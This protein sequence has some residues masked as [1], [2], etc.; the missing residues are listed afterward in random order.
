MLRWN[1]I[2]MLKWIILVSCSNVFADLESGLE[3]SQYWR[4]D[5][6]DVD[7]GYNNA[8]KFSIGR[9]SESKSLSF[10]KSISYVTAPCLNLTTGES[11]TYSLW[12]YIKNTTKDKSPT[13][14]AD[15]RGSREGFYLSV[16]ERAIRLTVVLGGDHRELL[17]SDVEIKFNTWT[18]FAITF[19]KETDG[20]S[21]YIDGK[22]QEH[23]S[24]W[25]GIDYF[26]KEPTCTIGNMPEFRADTKYQLYGSV[27]DLYVLSTASDD[28]VHLL[29]GFPVLNK[30]A[31]QVNGSAVLVKWTPPITGQCPV[32][33][34]S[35]YY[36]E[37]LSTEWTS[38]MVMKNTT[39]YVLQLICAK[40]YEIGVTAWNTN[41]ETSLND[42][43]LW[44]VTTGGAK[45]SPPVITNLEKSNC[46]VNLTWSVNED[47][48]CPLIKYTIHY[49]QIQAGGS[50][51]DSWSKIDITTVSKMTHQW[52]LQCDT[53]YEFAV[54]A[55]NVM[56]QSNLSATWQ[57]KTESLQESTTGK[58]IGIILGSISAFLVMIVA[59][60]CYRRRLK[61]NRR[62]STI[63]RKWSKS[64]ITPLHHLE[65][66]PEQ[67]TLLEE[68]GRGAFGKVHKAVLRESPGVEVFHSN[69]R[70]KRV[71]FKEGRTIAVKVLSALANEQ[72]KEQ[73]VEEIDLMKQIG[74]HTNVLSMIGFWTR[75]EPFLLLL[76]YAPCGD[77]LHWLRE[78]R[79]Q[80]D[81]GKFPQVQKMELLT[82][83]TAKTKNRQN[84][85]GI[86]LNIL[87]ESQQDK[88]PR[89][90]N[91][92][93]EEMKN[94]TNEIKDREVNN[95]IGQFQNRSHEDILEIKKIAFD[96]FGQEVDEEDNKSLESKR[97]IKVELDKRCTEPVEVTQEA[98]DDV[99]DDTGD[100][101][102]KDMLSF[103][104]Q[105]ARGM[106][107]LSRRGFIHRDL[108]AR[109]VL[110]GED[111]H[112]KIAD[113]G[114]MRHTDGDIYEVKRQ[115]KLPIKWMAP[116]AIKDSIYT[117]QSDVWSYGIL[118]WEMSTMGGTP[119][120][121]INNKELR[122][123]LYTGY[124]LERPDS[125][126]QEL[127]SLM[128]ECWKED[129]RRRPT[130]EQIVGLLEAMMMRD[131]PYFDFNQLDESHSYYNVA[132]S[133]SCTT[134]MK[135]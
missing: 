102:A 94:G 31:N 74:F 89:H 20:L 58:T 81:I 18:H 60:F 55:W 51:E 2:N 41:G 130:F 32:H 92:V 49:R 88:E 126:S 115:K 6:S 82:P 28:T 61:K 56:G 98:G 112:V 135:E 27:M 67:V 25:Q 93:N 127:Y 119:Y 22:K 106:S 108:A 80:V 90:S 95:R 45:P 97:F 100:L 9:C 128:L 64:D 3:D 129:P 77:L 76:E 16:V 110:V 48:H 66:W 114:L 83:D 33:A 26:K 35:I 24:L 134:E 118:L 72:D 107:Y 125:C 38:I 50:N 63:K 78:K 44:K 73:F 91:E 42:S 99:N 96:N 29:R 36:K 46:W 122:H 62:R 113:F 21:L 133:V 75:S 34:H 13:F 17:K 70:G 71:Q 14:Y 111:K 52:S 5:G 59:T 4:L 1:S 7:I 86:T 10:N 43:K 124:R 23:A 54:S 84:T 65:V 123:L 47:A 120:P 131:T 69:I 53:Q 116:E 109:N 79:K 104:W 101:I 57:I 117:T 15:M 30:S 103:A 8:S 85:A 105:I 121:G 19:N 11:F 132:S 87:P 68:L 40:E 39:Q 12:M 37:V